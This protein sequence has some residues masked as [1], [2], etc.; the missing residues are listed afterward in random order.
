MLQ[1]NEELDT[2]L[3]AVF[4][5][6][7]CGIVQINEYQTQSNRKSSALATGIVNDHHGD[8]EG[9]ACK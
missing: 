2:I 4:S 8:R 6:E 7:N 5:S 9:R 3:P 1:F